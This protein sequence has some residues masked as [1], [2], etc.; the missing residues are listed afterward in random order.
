MPVGFL[1]WLLGRRVRMPRDQVTRLPRSAKKAAKQHAQAM[2]AAVQKIAGLPGIADVKQSKRLPRGFYALAEEY[3]NHYDAYAE[4]VR[5]FLPVQ[6]AHRP[7]EPGGCGACYAVPM[8]MH[9][10][11]TL[12]LYRQVRTHREFQAMGQ[13][14][15][16]LGEQQFKDI[17]AGHTGKDPEKIRMGGRAV[18]QGRIAFAKRRLACPFLN[19]DKQRCR[20][21]D[22]RPIVCRMHYA[23]G[24]AE[25]SDPGHA[26][27]PRGARAYNIRPP[28][29]V[30]VALTQLDKRM[31][32]ELSPFLYAGVLQL[33]QLADGE[34]LQEVGEA[35]R[36]MQQDGRIA[37]RAN[38]NVR[39]AKKFQKKKKKRR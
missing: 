15:G 37:E 21:W 16:E 32:L 10:V 3:L 33:V 20:I 39:H 2:L 38:R 30:Q 6:D 28:I 5:K 7:G 17:Q 23:V 19:E 24:A 13:R 35:P 34:L 8:G 18:R 31:M 1:G 25:A 27:Y 36:R 9:A 4:V 11:D 14:M 29:K 22:D 12:Y 26:D